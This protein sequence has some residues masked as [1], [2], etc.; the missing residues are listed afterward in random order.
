MKKAMKYV[1]PILA[2]LVILNCG[3][4]GGSSSSQPGPE[5]KNPVTGITVS[6]D[7]ETTPIEADTVRYLEIEEELALT[8]ALRPAGI[9]GTVTWTLSEDWS[10]VLDIVV[11]DDKLSA[12]LTGV[13]EGQVEITVSARNND[14]ETPVTFTFT[15]EVVPVGALPVQSLTIKDSDDIDIPNNGSIDLFV[16]ESIDLTAELG[17][18]GVTGTVNWNQDGSV[19]TISPATGYNVTVTGSTEGTSTITV[20][21]S[22]ENNREPVT[23][24]FTVNVLPT[25]QVPD[26]WTERNWTQFGNDTIYAVAY[27][28][29]KF[30]AGGTSGKIIYATEDMVWTV[31][32]TALNADIRGIAFGSGFFVAGTNGAAAA[33]NLHRSADGLSWTAMSGGIGGI[34][35]VSPVG[36]RGFAAGGQ[37]NGGQNRTFSLNI[38]PSTPMWSISQVETGEGALT[39]VVRGLAYGNGKVVAV[40]DGGNIAYS[41]DNG[42]TWTAAVSGVTQGI[43]EVAFGRGKFV[44]VGGGSTM[45]YSTDGAAWAPI[46]EKGELSGS[47]SAIAYDSGYFV[48][49]DNNGKAAYSTD[50]INWTASTT[51]P[52]AS[53][54]AIAFGGDKWVAVGS[55]GKIFYSGGEASVKYPLM[56]LGISA[57]SPI[58]SIVQGGHIVVKQWNNDE[59]SGNITTLTAAID[60]LDKPGQSVT[61]AAAQADS[62][63]V[64]ITPASN[65]L[66][67]DLKGLEKGG[68]YTITVTA[69]NADSVT[70]LTHTFMVSVVNPAD[71]TPVKTMVVKYG[72]IVI[73]DSGSIVLDVDE[74]K[75]LTVSLSDQN[76]APVEGDITWTAGNSNVSLTETDTGATVTGTLAGGSLTITVSAENEFNAITGDP[77]VTQTFTVSVIKAPK[78]GWTTAE[79]GQSIFGAAGDDTQSVW[80]IA[81]GNGVWVAGGVSTSGPTAKIAVSSDNGKNWTEATSYA[82]A[83]IGGYISAVAFINGTVKADDDHTF[84]SAFIAGNNNGRVFASEDGNTW[85]TMAGNA[86]VVGTGYVQS[87]TYADGKILATDRSGGTRV[88]YSDDGGAT[89]KESLQTSGAGGTAEVMWGSAYGNGIWLVTGGTGGTVGSIRW[90]TDITVTSGWTVA[91]LPKSYTTLINKVVYGNEMFVAVGASGVILYSPDGKTWTEAKGS[92]GNLNALA[93]ANGYFVAGGD[94][95]AIWYSSDG[96]NWSTQ[97]AAGITATNPHIR[98]VAFS[99]NTWVAGGRGASLGWYSVAP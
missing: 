16:G 1:L 71:P 89:W 14:N 4:G 68:P 28:N 84:T 81:Y 54:Q 69:S 95:N 12:V 97:Q 47:I 66:S 48:A 10:D 18:G 91:T 92:G 75:T 49:I 29:G 30:V 19:A 35:G 60:P 83:N 74:T 61:W 52:N 15:V 94:S 96:I 7:G 57:P 59:Y 51:S 50:G 77:A 53:I 6:V 39:G 3:G 82:L 5:V 32:P 21:A 58:G 2:V 22:N 70:P 43:Q 45:I 44:A 87:F 33:N 88:T 41:S 42:M 76:E 46:T 9:T 80:G 86:Q 99:N 93:Y 79:T 85:Y 40:G 64:S 23:V 72:E 37:A 73:P 26:A 11:S 62:N 17:P 25:A 55:N 78:G 36:E 67:A 38:T 56:S 65:G 63:K 34:L 31:L 90:S 27:G 8:V 20:S 13:D 98:A 24:T